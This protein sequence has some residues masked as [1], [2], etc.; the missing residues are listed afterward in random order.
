MAAQVYLPRNTPSVGADHDC[1]ACIPEW[2][3]GGTTIV[4]YY[5]TAWWYLLGVARSVQ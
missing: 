4:S 3:Q 1:V 5:S 2:Y